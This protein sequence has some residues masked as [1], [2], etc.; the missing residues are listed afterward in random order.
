VRAAVTRWALIAGAT[1]IVALGMLPAV[2][3]ADEMQA[4][5]L[6]PFGD[7]EIPN[8]IIDGIVGIGGDVMA[9]LMR[10]VPFPF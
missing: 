2:G 4:P 5:M 10:M 7:N 6:E 1:A 8:Q 9:F 3:G